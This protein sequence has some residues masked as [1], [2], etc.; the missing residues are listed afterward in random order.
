M[1]N[2]A[3]EQ[4]VKEVAALTALLEADC[5]ARHDTE[6]ESKVL[7]QKAKEMAE[8]TVRLEAERKA[9]AELTAVLEADRRAQQ[10]W[11]QKNAQQVAGLLRRNEPEEEGI[12]LQDKDC[13]KLEGGH[14]NTQTLFFV[15]LMS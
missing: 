2:K 8:S 6:V 10:K 1:D 13:E 11:F 3:F 14:P 9:R 12:N 4:K 5:K 7:E 15:L